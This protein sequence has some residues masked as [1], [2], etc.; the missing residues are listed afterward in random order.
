MLKSN[1]KY[2][3]TAWCARIGVVATLATGT[4]SAVASNLDFLNDTPMSYIN[5]SDIESIKRALADALNTNADGEMRRWM[6]DGTGNSIQIS[7][8]LTPEST[9][10]EGSRTCRHVLVV[11][12]AKGQSMDF[13]PD[14]CRSPQ[15]EW[16][17]QK[18]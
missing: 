3:L 13:H 4:A 15:E 12:V 6:N 1:R 10:R 8:M 16:T 5:N 11:L 18:R 7:G 9:I 17:L 14:F 2:A